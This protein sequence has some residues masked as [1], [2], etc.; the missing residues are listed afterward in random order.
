MLNRITTNSKRLIQQ[1]K[2]WF[3]PKYWSLCW[4]VK[5]QKSIL[6]GLQINF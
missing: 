5:Y 2:S 1:D 3:W 4:R 6:M